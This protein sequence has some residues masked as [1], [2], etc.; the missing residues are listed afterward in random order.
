[1]KDIP[2]KP[3]V[4]FFKDKNGGLL[5]IG[6]AKS[7]RKRVSSYFK[8]LEDPRLRM[9]VKK[10]DDIEY[11]VTESEVDAT[12]LEAKLIHDLQPK[13]NILS[14]DDK[15]FSQILITNYDDFAKVWVVRQRDSNKGERFGPFSSAYDMRKALK[16]LQR[17][18]KFATCSLTISENDPKRRFYRP[19]LLYSISRCSG[20]CA[21]LVS[22]SDYDS[23]IESLKKFLSG[24]KEKLVK[25]LKGKMKQAADSFDYERA[26]EIR[27]QL[28][29]IETLQTKVDGEDVSE[30]EI[31]PL[32]PK[33]YLNDL[34]KLLGLAKPP[35]TIEA[36][37]IANVQGKEAVGSIVT[38]LD[39]IPNKSGYRRFKIRLPEEPNDYAM[40]QEVISRRFKR[41][42][43]SDEPAPDILLIDGGVGQLRAA[44]EVIK[45]YSYTM[46][47][48]VSLAK[49]NEELFIGEDGRK[50]DC[51]KSSYGLRLLMYA[52]DEAH[53]FAQHYHH[54]LRSKK[55]LGKK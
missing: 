32:D 22:K 16:G 19:C 14:K 12:L 26:A 13:Y 53:R 17:V 8:Q 55:V 37:D 36:C 15:S 24:E 33:E 54:I 6:K 49:K 39:G 48:V 25:N 46:P 43:E 21:G 27:D 18:F 3:G 38:F 23:D 44:I 1:M 20:P 9:M 2:D 41:I 10:I 30:T 34:A 42:K 11:H 7:V 51:P 29:S 5:Y 40:I 47:T 28:K 50:I 52:R 35:R 45:G 31:T 4:Y